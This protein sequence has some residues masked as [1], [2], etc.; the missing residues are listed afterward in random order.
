MFATQNFA[1]DGRVALALVIALV[2]VLKAEGK[3]LP[4][5]VETMIEKAEG[6]LNG[7]G[8][9]DDEARRVLEGLPGSGL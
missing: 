1:A 7:T 2:Q 9:L 5:D 8:V 6:M 3:L 4:K